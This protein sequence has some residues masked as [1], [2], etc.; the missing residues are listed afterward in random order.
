MPLKKPSAPAISPEERARRK[1]YF[2]ATVVT[3]VAVIMVASAIHVVEMGANRLE[4]MRSKAT[5]D[6]S[7]MKQRIR[8][9]GE[10]IERHRLHE[11]GQQLQQIY[12]LTE[13]DTLIDKDAWQ[14]LDTMV[15]IPAAEFFMG[16]DRKMADEQD[17]PE[18]RV[19]LDD[20]RMD[21]YLVTNVEYARFVADQGYRP[22]LDW[23]KGR[24]SHEKLTHPVTMVSWNDA[25]AYCSWAGKRLPTEKEWEKAARG[26][27]GLRWPWGNSME[28]ERLNTYYNVGS[29]TE[30]WHYEEGVSPY[31]LYDMAGNVSQWVEDDFLPYE[32]SK[33]PAALFMAKQLV[34]ETTKE[35]AMKVGE[36][37]TLD[38][39]YK[40]RR[41]GS[42]KSDPFSTSSYH[43]NF[44]LPN[45]ASDFFGFRCAADLVEKNGK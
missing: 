14:R 7:E 21:K 12:T 16:T 22:P 4:S 44:S 3:C 15:T 42:W 23:E 6:I 5:Y 31:G 40:V 35:R 29:T 36:L 18:H 43:R 25:K 20:Y 37:V 1:R 27:D 10:D 17:K 34:A 9:A 45:Y 19:Y 28:R 11:K 13:V 30:V 32:G 8:A 38:L 24:P 26:V 41:G 33:A 39:R 2:A